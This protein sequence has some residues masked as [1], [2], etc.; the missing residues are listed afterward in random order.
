MLL[1]YPIFY[2]QFGL[3]KLANLE[4]PKLHTLAD[5]VSPK[6]SVLHYWGEDVSVN[7]PT[8][9]DPWFGIEKGKLGRIYHVKKY[10]NPQ[11]I[12]KPEP[13][14]KVDQEILGYKQREKRILISDSMKAPSA[15]AEPLIINYSHLVHGFFYIENKMTGWYRSVNLLNA[16]IQGLNESCDK[17]NRQQFVKIKAPTHFISRADMRLAAANHDETY[18]KRLNTLDLVCYFELWKWFGDHRVNSLFNQIKPQHLSRINFVFYSG[19]NCSVVNL[20]TVDQWRKSQQGDNTSDTYSKGLSGL[21]ISN[22]FLKFILDLMSHR[23]DVMDNVEVLVDIDEDLAALNHVADT[24]SAGE[25][26]KS[27]QTKETPTDASDLEVLLQDNLLPSVSKTVLSKTEIDAKEVDNFS[28]S[29]LEQL[30]KDRKTDFNSPVEELDYEINNKK[31]IQA[32][33]DYLEDMDAKAQEAS[34]E[35]PEDLVLKVYEPV[36]HAEAAQDKLDKLLIETRITPKEHQRLSEIANGY[37]KLKVGPKGET[38]EV[39]SKIGKDITE[40]KGGK[41]LRKSKGVKDENMTYRTLEQLNRDYVRHVHDKTVAAILLNLQKGGVFVT[42]LEKRVVETAIGSYDDYEIQLAQAEGKISNV[43]FKVQHL[44]EDGSFMSNNVKYRMRRQKF[45]LPIRK[46]NP[47]TVTLSAYA[48]KINIK[49]NQNAVNNQSTWLCNH[50]TRAGF[51]VENTA[52]TDFRPGTANDQSVKRPRLVTSLASRVRG[53]KADGF[54]YDLSHEAWLQEPEFKDLIKI[55]YP[56]AKNNKGIYVVVI[57]EET[58]TLS[59]KGQPVPYDFFGVIGINLKRQPLEFVDVLIYNKKLPMGFVLAYEM[60]FNNLIKALELK[61]EPRIVPKGTRVKLENHEYPISFKEDT[62]VFSKKDL[63]ATSILGGLAAME[64]VTKNYMAH[65]LNSPDVYASILKD[66]GVGR[67]YLDKLDSY[68][69]FFLDAITIEILQEM[70]EPVNLRGLF[71]RAAELLLTDDS[72]REFDTSQMR[73]RGLERVAGAIHSEI[74][75]AIEEQRNKPNRKTK[76]ITLNPYAVWEAISKDTSVMLVESI[77]PIRNL[78]ENEALTMSG[79]GGRK[80]ETMTKPTRALDEN[81]VGT[82]S[83]STLDSG[84]VGINMYSSANPSFNSMWGTTNRIDRQELDPTKILSTSAMLS[85]YVKHDD[86]KRVGFISIQYEHGIACKG[87]RVLPVRTSYEEMIAQ[88]TDDVFAKAAEMNGKVISITESGIIVEYEDGTQ[89]GVEL[90]TV[91]GNSGGMT[92]PHSI[93]TTLK[94]GDVFEAG[95]IIAY[96]EGWFTQEYFDPKAVSLKPGVPAYVALV[97][98]NGTLADSSLISKNLSEALTTTL[99]TP[100]DV[101][102]D[103]EFGISNLVKEGQVVQADTPLCLI[104]EP[105][106]YKPTTEISESTMDLLAMMSNGAPAAQSKGV[107]ER[108]E[109]FY[110]GDLEDMSE[111]LRALVKQ[112]DGKRAKRR[113][114]VAKSVIT[115]EVDEGYRVNGT[116]LQFE[117]VA[118]KIYINKELPSEFADKAVFALQLKSTHGGVLPKPIKTLGGREIDALFSA[119]AYADRIVMSGEKMGF[120]NA[121]LDALGEQAVELYERS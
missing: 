92:F 91:Y 53:F 82:V 3:R 113:K 112:Y 118:L 27:L 74:V 46:I 4:T 22:R 100:R 65:E 120:H 36:S 72:P 64:K 69:D 102:I 31:H 78:K 81:D 33:D 119:Q 13:T 30:Y 84:K 117:Q 93:V 116:P 57:N 43:R 40:I 67:R 52:V 66:Y 105:G 58:Y 76:D 94:V 68:Y 21:D 107:V 17:N 1:L 55:G 45:D 35:E 48:G 108:I 32:L 98:H 49:R 19:N 85:P 77:N 8:F 12:I 90:G 114:A 87:Y 14:Y 61:H 28:Q 38:L 11:G 37:K 121:F 101:V 51:D 104:E 16:L 86:N 23:N 20:K 34:E 111:S 6:A 79:T 63:L 75:K 70:Q 109:V 62:Y 73:F 41:K 24:P 2:K 110:N 39:Y 5:L 59:L 7:G 89:Q 96:N 47:T 103:F 56:I 18:L 25:A 10:E 115:G 97:E 95:Q 60:G 80:D 9:L 44:E 50:L 26:P 83:E 42:K 54:T 99:S 15:D 29:L 71:I 88:S 106:T